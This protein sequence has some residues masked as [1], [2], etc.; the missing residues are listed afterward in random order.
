MSGSG[1]SSSSPEQ[2]RARQGRPALASLEQGAA[3]V[4]EFS[5]SGGDDPASV[6]H[7]SEDEDG[8]YALYRRRFP[9][10]SQET[11]TKAE[12]GA[13]VPR[14]WE[15]DMFRTHARLGYVA[16]NVAPE[17]TR[18]GRWKE[19][20][21]LQIEAKSMPCK[22]MAVEV[23]TVTMLHTPE[24]MASATDKYEQ[25]DP[26]R[27]MQMVDFHNKVTI[28]KTHESVKLT[29]GVSEVTDLERRR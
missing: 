22:R 20:C 29:K 28:R 7:S 26:D 21:N 8:E 4:E 10:D 15:E 13:S 12:E 16:R 1:S 5:W 25:L 24:Q 11:G 17:E 27:P 9:Y 23:L 3:F 6:T 14:G 19:W 18:E 2:P